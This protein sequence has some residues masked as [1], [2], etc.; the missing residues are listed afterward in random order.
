MEAVSIRAFSPIANVLFLLYYS[1][2]YQHYMFTIEKLENT[3]NEKEGKI[4]EFLSSSRLFH[5]QIFALKIFSLM[6]KIA[7]IS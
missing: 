1:L 4:S 6:N 3:V 2:S 7:F 5:F